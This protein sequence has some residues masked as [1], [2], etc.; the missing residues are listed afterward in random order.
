M[1]CCT[2]F[3]DMIVLPLYSSMAAALPAIKPLLRQV[4]SNHAHWVSQD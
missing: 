3:F 4:R 2:Q 1:P